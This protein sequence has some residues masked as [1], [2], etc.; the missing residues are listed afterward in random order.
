MSKPF[1]CECGNLLN[2]S[3]IPAGRRFSCPSCGVSR[4]LDLSD[5]GMLSSF[6]DA[7]GVYNLM[8]KKKLS[9]APT[10]DAKLVTEGL[11]EEGGSAGRFD[12]L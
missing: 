9:D 10:L 5:P 4:I 3:E 11:V 12:N 2:V 8:L 7:E 6:T 1:L